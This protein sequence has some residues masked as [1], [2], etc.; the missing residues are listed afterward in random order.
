[1]HATPSRSEY[2]I[3]CSVCEYTAMS[4]LQNPNTL[5]YCCLRIRVYA[6]TAPTP[7]FMLVFMNTLTSMKRPDLCPFSGRREGPSAAREWERELSSS[8]S[9]SSSR[10]APGS[11]R[12]RRLQPVTRLQR[13]RERVR[14]VRVPRLQRVRERVRPGVRRVRPVRVSLYG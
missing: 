1:M 10:W 6:H 8:S 9:S 4:G 5:E 2:C 12:V 13:V 14:R 11:Q 3:L 7:V